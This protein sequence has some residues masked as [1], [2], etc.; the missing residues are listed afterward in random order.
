MENVLY[1]Y[2]IS[3]FDIN[4]QNWNMKV[5]TMN[6]IWVYD[7]MSGEVKMILVYEFI[8]KFVFVFKI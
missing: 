3:F 2:T 7:N 4:L 8:D 6:M 1:T 5:I